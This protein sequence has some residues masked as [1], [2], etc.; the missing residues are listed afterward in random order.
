MVLE[1]SM[2]VAKTDLKMALDVRYVKY[3]MVVAGGFGPVMAILMVVSSLLLGI[4]ELLSIMVLY[5][6]SLIGL[7][8]IMPASLIAANALVGEKE[9]RTLE[10]LLC[11]PLSDKELLMGKVLSSLIPS[12]V[13][14][15][16]G[17]FATMIAA[18]ITLLFLNEPFMIIPDISGLVLIFGAGP[19]MVLAVIAVM[20]LI[21]G[22][23]TRVYEAYQASGS[24]IILFLIPMFLPLASMQNEML[25]PEAVWFSVLLT[26]LLGVSLMVITWLIAFTRFNRNNMV[27]LV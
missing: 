20:I 1:K 9:Q 2:V 12:M 25:N 3:S 26:V 23:V 7:F 27:Q 10:P 24:V 5:A 19:P 13:M 14:I 8:A 15:I 16:V 22:K 17:T 21:S 18:N 6:S 11:T 4:P